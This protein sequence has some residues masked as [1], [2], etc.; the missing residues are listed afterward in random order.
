MGASPY[1]GQAP[2]GTMQAGLIDQPIFD[3]HIIN[4]MLAYPRSLFQPQT[5]YRGRLFFR[6][7][8]LG[9]W[10]DPMQ[11]PVLVTTNPP[12]TPQNQVG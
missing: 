1:G 12:G 5:P 6:G 4:G 3:G 2:Y 8:Y 11:T 7:D 10:T 9:W